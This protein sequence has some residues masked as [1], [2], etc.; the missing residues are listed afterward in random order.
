[1]KKKLPYKTHEIAFDEKNSRFF[2]VGNAL[3]AFDIKTNKAI[4]RMSDIPYKNHIY[5][6]YKNN[7]AIL[8][9]TDGRFAIYSLDELELLGII[10]LKGRD[11][12]TDH[13]FCYDEE[14]NKLYGI[15]LQGLTQYWVCISPDT[16]E[17][18]NDL[19][20]EDVYSPEGERS[21]YTLIK[22]SNGSVYM[23]RGYYD[24]NGCV[25]SKY[26]RYECNGGKLEYKETIMPKF[27]NSNAPTIISPETYHRLRN[28]Y[29]EHKIKGYPEK[30][31]KFDSGLYY[32]SSEAIYRA[33]EDGE[34][35]EIYSGEYISDYAEYNGRRYICTWSF[36]IVQDIES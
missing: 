8:S 5:I 9:S 7:L 12:H 35:E 18:T 36:C 22:Y 19:C 16:L 10:K 32:I 17:Y 29:K 24:K 13:H 26:E 20:M 31:V 23:T 21:S 33:K 25:C 30:E 3:Y 2:L 11:V 27:D 6:S 34:F 15:M 1:M 14:H 28:L 4:K